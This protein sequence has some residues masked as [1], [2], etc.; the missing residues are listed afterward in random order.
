MSICICVVEHRR[1]S[2]V[3]S[4]LY[5]PC[6]HKCTEWALHACCATCAS[7][8]EAH[9]KYNSFPVCSACNHI[10]TV[11]V[12]EASS[13]RSVVDCLDKRG[14]DCG[15]LSGLQL[16]NQLI[17]QELASRATASSREMEV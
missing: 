2:S 15:S 14:R 13:V 7:L 5:S 9:H 6:C 12:E 17:K 11:F 1:A 8:T 10:G 16:G 3:R 4:W